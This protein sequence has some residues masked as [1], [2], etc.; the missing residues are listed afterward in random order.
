[1]FKNEYV[2][3]D[4]LSDQIICS[5][6][7]LVSVLF[8]IYLGKWVY[9]R[10][11]TGF[12]L[13]TELVKRDN[14]ALSLAVVGYFFGLILA[15]TGILEGPSLS[16]IDDVIDI[17]FYGIVSIIILNISVIVNNKLILY[18]FDNIKEIIHD[19]NVGTGIVEAANHIAMGLIIFGAVSGEGGD[20]TTFIVFWLLG[21]AVLIIAGHCYNWIMPFS[22]HD[23]IEK[24]NVAVGVAFAGMLIGIGNII[25]ISISGDF[26]S[27]HNHLLNC[28]VFIVFGLLLLPV[29]RFITDKLLLP[30]ERLTDEL[31]NQKEPNV[32]AGAIEAFA[33]IGASF[34]IGSVL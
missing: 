30:G 18:K 9:N 19:K 15:I 34:L 3:V 6:I 2:G 8:I 20:L 29:I 28:S 4:M 23:E 13:K 1:M 21:Q 14:L 31:V 12:D 25:R 7:Y 5:I 11:N 27:W 16:W 17:G 32:G 33:Y 26:I 24:D 10:L 22:V